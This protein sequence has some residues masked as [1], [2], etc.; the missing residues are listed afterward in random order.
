M[1]RPLPRADRSRCNR[2]RI[3]AHRQGP[4][5]TAPGRPAH[6]HTAVARLEIAGSVAAAEEAAELVD[7][8]ADD[9]E[10]ERCSGGESLASRWPGSPG[11]RSFAAGHL[12]SIRGSRYCAGGP[13]SS[14]DGPRYGCR[15]IVAPPMCAPAPA[16]S[17]LTSSFGAVS[18]RHR[19]RRRR[20][21][22]SPRPG[23]RRP[24]SG[25]Q[26]WLAA[27]FALGGRDNGR[28]AVRPHFGAAVPAS[29][30]TA[31]G[32]RPRPRRWRARPG[33]HTAGLVR[34]RPGIAS[35]GW[36]FVEVGGEQPDLLAPA[37]RDQG[38]TALAVWTDEEGDPRGI[39]A[40]LRG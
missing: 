8:A 30:R 20:D 6:P 26:R 11:P 40:R 38:F 23:Q 27:G 33:G 28:T 31:V 37:L 9:E 2:R 12:V 21:R 18:N 14:R 24:G 17:P 29:R 5:T 25:R 7:G 36:L 16:P 13:E 19:H 3:S 1:A 4:G 34:G 10:L 22:R 15:P 35:R 32:A 39:K